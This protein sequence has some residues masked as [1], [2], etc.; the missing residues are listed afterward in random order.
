MIHLRHEDYL[1]PW[2]WRTK[3]E[4]EGGGVFIDGGIHLVDTLVYLGGLP[5]RVYAARPPQV[6]HDVEGE[7]GIVVIAH[8]P[9]GAL[10]LINFSRATCTSGPKDWATVTGSEGSFSFDPFG[11]EVAVHTPTAHRTVQVSDSKRGIRPMV[12]EFRASIQEDREPAMSGE[13]GLNDLAVVLAAYRSAEQGGEVPV[14][15][16]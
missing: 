3:V 14:T 13:E 7:D 9:G 12:Q 15:V 8:L 16:R 11:R 6:F 5:E 4:P 1:S 10:G 2:G